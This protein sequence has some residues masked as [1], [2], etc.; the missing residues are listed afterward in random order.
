MRQLLG[1]ITSRY[2]H[3]RVATVK[4]GQR[5]SRHPQYGPFVVYDALTESLRLLQGAPP[6]NEA[7]LSR[8]VRHV[9]LAVDRDE[10]V[11]ATMF[12]RRGVSGIPELDVHTLEWTDVGWRVPGGGSGLGEQALDQRAR[13]TDLEAPG[14]SQGGGG[15][16]RTSSRHLGWSRDNWVRWGELRLA[17]E[18]AVL[19]V[20]DRL[21][22]VAAHGM[23]V[24]VWTK[25]APAVTAVDRQGNVLGAVP[26]GGRQSMPALYRDS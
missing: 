13:L 22:P 25:Q 24:V 1:N 20:G 5:V 4:R 17:Q 23:A 14:K 26:W 10:D 15:T 9:P 3:G 6:S 7:R 2:R 18:V 8:R 11:A 21:L 16:A 12:L 19:R